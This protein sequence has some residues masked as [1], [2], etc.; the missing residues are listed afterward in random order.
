MDKHINNLNKMNWEIYVRI[1]V[2]SIAIM[3]LTFVLCGIVDNT[4]LDVFRNLAYDSI[5][6]TLVAALI[7]LQN[8][9]KKTKKLTVYMI[10]YIVI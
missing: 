4:V 6:S 5:A 1:G 2:V 9:R 3:V 7:E 8:I 10:S